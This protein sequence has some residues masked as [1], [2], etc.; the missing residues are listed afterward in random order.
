MS[1]SKE[2][3][4]KVVLIMKFLFK[5]EIE[6]ETFLNNLRENNSGFGEVVYSS[7]WE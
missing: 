3:K 2:E 5:N 1:I 6:S 4:G 7:L